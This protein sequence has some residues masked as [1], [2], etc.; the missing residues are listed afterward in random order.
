MAK[1]VDLLKDKT[2]LTY[3]F[4]VTPDVLEADLENLAIEPLFY[5]VTWHAKSHLNKDLDIAPLRLA[6]LLRR[7]NKNV[8]L[9]L[10]CD[11]LKK[12]YLVK[13]LQMLQE[14]SI[15]NLF[16]IL[17]ENFDPDSS[18]F[19]STEE[20]ITAI[21]NETRDYFCIGVA[22]TPNCDDEKLNA[23]KKKVEVGAN[24]IITQAFFESKI[25]TSFYDRC[26]N[27]QINVPI[28]PGLFYFETYK[29]LVGFTNLCKIKV[30]EDVLQQSE[31]DVEA[32]K[33][34]TQNL[35]FSLKA[36]NVHHVHFFTLNKLH[37][38]SKFI[39]LIL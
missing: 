34:I 24:F 14:N 7:K 32:G 26:K 3:S 13:L 29:Q 5:S 30:S 18:D 9:H 1:V 15:R 19:K 31:K 22:G 23:L 33:I 21:R 17:G 36:R 6:R 28:I 16:V 4:E 39:K 12:N 8:L 27:V 2:Q 38:V 37:S 10:T 11:L 25:F 35:I 20:L